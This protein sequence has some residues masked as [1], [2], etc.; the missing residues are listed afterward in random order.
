MTVEFLEEA[1]EE[2]TEAALVVRVET[3]RTRCTVS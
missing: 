1:E 3:S 2:L